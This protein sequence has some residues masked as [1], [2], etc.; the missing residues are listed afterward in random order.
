[1]KTPFMKRLLELAEKDSRIMFLTGDLGFGMIEPFKERFP[2]QYLNVG[3]AEQNMMGIAT[4]LALEGRIPFTYSIANFGTLRCLEQIR[5]DV[6]YHELNVNVVAIGGGFSYGALGI[7]HHATEDLAIM[8]S[9]PGM[10]VIAPG[11]AWEAAEATEALALCSGCSY[12]RL[13]KMIAP[14]THIPGEKFEIGKGRTIRKGKDFSLV[15]TGGILK[16]VCE[17]AELLAQQKI[18]CRVISMH[19]VKPLDEGCLLQAAEETGGVI[20]VEEHTSEGG[21]GGAVS[22]FYMEKRGETQGFSPHGSKRR[23]LLYCRKSDLSSKAVWLGCGL[24]G[25]RSQEI[26]KGLAMKGFLYQNTIKRFFDISFSFFGLIISLPVFI[27]VAIAVFFQDF[28]S[29][30]YIA[31]RTGRFGRKF[32]MIK[33]RSMVIDAD[34]AG[35]DS[36]ATTDPRITKVGHF[37]RKYKLDELTQLWN[38]LIGDMSVVGPRPNV[39]RETDLYTEEEKKLLTIQPGITDFSSIV[40]SDEGEILKSRHD[41][42][43]AY[44]QLVRPGKSRLSLFYVEHRSLIVDIEL[45]IFTLIA[46]VSRGIALKKVQKLLRSL[47]ASE[48]LILLAGREERLSPAPP[49]GSL[50]IVT[51]RG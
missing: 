20:T 36:T 25:F 1:M 45:I 5:N 21:F 19:T 8:R 51:E 12:L 22:E 34:K 24:C 40:F 17:A 44:H 35:V 37:I 43:L 26:I 47:G 33:L 18:D 29:P 46:L 3:V 2:K 14:P 15:A 27:P 6:A 28:H 50:R 38:V 49:P 4:G 9:I 7:S 11:D 32:K 10:T 31:H 30:F 13:D 41:P 23:I 48:K 16:N 42:D 39:A